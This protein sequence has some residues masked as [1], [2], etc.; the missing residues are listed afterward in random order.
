MQHRQKFI[1]QL[2]EEFKQRLRTKMANNEEAKA[3]TQALIVQGMLRMMEKHILIEG[4][5]GQK[6]LIEEVIPGCEAQFAEIMRGETEKEM[7]ATLSISNYSLET[8]HH[9]IIG[10]VFLR[11]QDGL[12]VC[13]NSLDAR[14]DLALEQLL[15]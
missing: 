15:P 3:I 1:D 10:G 9:D 6:R 13:D 5:E 8:K 12:I 2:K 14:I 11:S 7:Q 4:A